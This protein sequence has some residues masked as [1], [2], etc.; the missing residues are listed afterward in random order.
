MALDGHS[1][2]T[3][4]PSTSLFPT[5][6]HGATEGRSAGEAFG[7]H[8]WGPGAMSN[9]KAIAGMQWRCGPGRGGRWW[10]WDQHS[11]Q[12]C[13]MLLVIE[14][15]TPLLNVLETD[16]VKFLWLTYIM[17]SSPF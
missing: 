5:R 16:V 12:R 11:N 15:M 8:Q 14:C 13:Y 7:S 6:E 9:Q 3:E 1:T 4:G 2:R 17:H 10:H